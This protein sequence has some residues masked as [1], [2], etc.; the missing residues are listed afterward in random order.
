MPNHP[1][2]LLKAKRELSALKWTRFWTLLG[3]FIE[4]A[5]YK[6]ELYIYTKAS[7][8]MVSG[9]PLTQMFLM[10][11]LGGLK[12]WEWDCSY[13]SLGADGRAGDPNFD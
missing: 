10:A 12:R 11:E 9:S 7:S 5:V 3:Q 6:I 2:A 8:T 4:S 1:P 13:D